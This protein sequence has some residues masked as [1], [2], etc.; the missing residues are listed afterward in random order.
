MVASVAEVA[1]AQVEAVQVARPD[2]AAMVDSE[3]AT[4]DGVARAVAIV[5]GK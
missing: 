2:V 1:V 5:T 3:V 4:V